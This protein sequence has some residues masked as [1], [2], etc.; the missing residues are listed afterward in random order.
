MFGEFA[1][2]M[3]GVGHEGDHTFPE[4]IMNVVWKLDDVGIDAFV[5]RNAGVEQDRFPARDAT[6]NPPPRAAMRWRILGFGQALIA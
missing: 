5:R 1:D 4:G 2:L 3:L 6:S